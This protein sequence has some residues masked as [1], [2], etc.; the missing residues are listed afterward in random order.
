MAGQWKFIHL[1]LYDQSDLDGLT[2]VSYFSPHQTVVN[3]KLEQFLRRFYPH[4]AVTASTEVFIQHLLSGGWEPY[5]DS[6]MPFE[7][8]RIISYSFRKEV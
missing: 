2:T 3:I 6:V 8:I 5:S 4:L 1:I 7:H